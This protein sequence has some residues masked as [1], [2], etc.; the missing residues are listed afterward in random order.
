MKIRAHTC[1]LGK[2]GFAAHA[3]SF[4]RALSKHAEVRVRNYTWDDNPHYLNEVDFSIIDQ[5][6]LSVPE[7]GQRD[8]P[9]WHSFPQHNW[10]ATGEFSPDAEIVLMDNDHYYFYEEYT[11]PVKIAYA[12]WESTLLPEK[13]FNQLLKFDYLWVVSDWHRKMAVLQGY[14]A[15]RIRVVNEGVD[16]EFFDGSTPSALEEY[17]DERFK[18][19]F[20]GRWDYRK[21]VPEIVGSFLKAFPNNE[22]VDLILSADNPFSVDGMN[23]TEER[24][25]HYGYQD[26]RIRVK[27]FVSR[28]DYVS[29]VKTGHVMLTCARSE[30]WNIPL[31]EAMA[32]GTPSIYSEYGGQLE[33]ARGKGFPVKIEKLMPANVGAHLGFAGATPGDYAEPDYNDLVRQMRYCYENY[34]EAKRKAVEESVDIA[35]RFNWETVGARGYEVLKGLILNENPT[36]KNEAAIVMSHADTPEKLSLLKNC[37]K[38]LK[39][40]GY[41]VIL[42]SHIDVPSKISEKADVLVVDRDNPVVYS[43]E[44]AQLSSTVPIHYIKFPDVSL[45]YNLD[46]NHGLAALKLIKNGLQIAREKGLWV[47]HCIN[48]DYIINDSKVLLNH[49][50]HLKDFSVVSYMW[51]G[52]GSLNS[53]LFSGKTQDLIDSLQTINTKKDYFRYNGKVILEDVMYAAL[54]EAGKSIKLFGIESIKKNNF[55]NQFILDTYPQIHCKGSVNYAYLCKSHKGEYLFGVLSGGTPLDIEVEYN[56]QLQSVTAISYPMN[57]YRVTEGMLSKGFT[58]RVR[59]AS[60]EAHYNQNSKTAFVEVSN[61]ALIKNFSFKKMETTLPIVKVHFVDGPFVEIL[62]E[63]DANYQVLFIDQDANEIIYTATIKNNCWARCNRKYFTN[64]KI[65]IRNMATGQLIEHLYNAEGKN[66]YISMGSSSLGDSIAWFAHC[67]EFAKKHKCKLTVST[68]KN[69]LFKDQYPN[70]QFVQPGTIAPDAYASYQIGWFYVENDGFNKEMHPRD[71]KALPMQATTTDILGLPHT[72]VRPRL[73]MPVGEARPI[74]EKYICIGMH[75][76][77]QAKYWNN[78]TGWQQIVDHF[79]SKGYSVVMLSTEHNGYMGNPHPH[80]VIE[81]SGERSLRST[82][83]YLQH[84]ELFIGVGSGLSWL[85]W[86]A[87]TKTVM[88][89]GFSWPTTEMEDG[90]VLRIHKSTG[91]NGCFNRHR[92]D[93]GDWNWCPDQKNSPRQ[94]ECSRNIT[95]TEVIQQIEEFLGGKTFT[96]EKTIEQIVQESYALGMV[97]NHSEIL[98]AAEFFKGLNVKDFIEIGTDQGG[99][100]AIWSKISD[101]DGTRVS[102]DLPHGQ[103]GRSDYDAKT[104]NEY[105]K[106]LGSDVHMLEGDSHCQCMKTDLI[107][108]LGDRKVDFLF[109]DGD[110]TYRGV[111]QDYHMYKEFVKPGGWIAFHDIKDTEFHRNANCRVD[112][113]WNELIGN[114][115]EFIDKSSEYG[116]I[117]FIQVP[118]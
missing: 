110:H 13:F 82:L 83:N 93:A 103:F 17:S 85:S 98:G 87:G 46:F 1:Y 107:C 114:K 102:I 11:A 28:E 111:K 30:G 84:A 31:I 97:Q 80:G 109:I 7:G 104:R 44:Y 37:I 64:W 69:E 68:F 72:T 4:F 71:F 59:E 91:C 105:L 89:S 117:G 79:R 58:I 75:S 70:I 51:N 41:T 24:L 95:G 55:V 53:G 22:P 12:V 101:S 42:S 50:A 90:N 20:F 40:Q 118:E 15:Y 92:L 3:R 39:S 21:A 34:E 57:F 77:A 43:E 60:Y 62:G 25:A 45:S 96:I 116:G 36:P 32:A 86:A 67:E 48:Y 65:Q 9:I 2:T 23:S 81:I 94:F 47:T 16:S 38:T 54:S 106:S 88:I 61:E 100:F 115:I 6:T 14:P 19:L 18:F 66:V 8:F 27:H 74:E 112:Q 29:Y 33:F 99:T 10:I 113:L 76:T 35:N 52:E 49:S 63:H 26:S 56:G 5:I 78:P 108:I 73:N